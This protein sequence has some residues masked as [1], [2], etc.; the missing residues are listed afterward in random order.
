MLTRL[1]SAYYYLSGTLYI[2]S[3]SG[4][5]TVIFFYMLKIKLLFQKLLSFD[6]KR[7]KNEFC[8]LQHYGSLKFD[9]DEHAIHSEIGV[10]LKAKKSKTVV[11]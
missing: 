7:H 11:Y 2:I 8:I 10:L 3:I 1:K 5:I 9:V 4:P 6:R